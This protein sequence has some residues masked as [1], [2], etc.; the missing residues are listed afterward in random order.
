MTPTTT[1]RAN[2]HPVGLVVDDDLMVREAVAAV[3]EDMCDH[4]YQ[5]SD[6]QEGL[7]VLDEHPEITL[8]VTDIAMPRLDGLSF[9]RQARRAHP[10]LKVLFVSGLQHPPESEEFLSKPFRTRALVSALHHLMEAH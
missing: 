5:A 2:S 8:I 6:G 1:Q 10:D 3:M 4:V 9:T 7:E